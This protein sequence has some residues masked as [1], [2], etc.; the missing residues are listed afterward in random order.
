[1]KSTSHGTSIARKA[2]IPLEYK[3]PNARGTLAFARSTELNSA[4]SEWFF[5]VDDNTSVLDSSHAGG[6]AVFA[7]VLGSGMSVID[8]IAAVP[9]FNAGT[10]TAF[11]TLPLRNVTSNQAT[12]E[13]ANFI[14][15]N[16]VTVVPVYPTDNVSTAV[17]GFAVANNN[18]A[19]ASATL[20]GSTLTITP[21][22]AGTAT[23]SLRA[24]DVNGNFASSTIT[25]T[26]AATSSSPVITVPPVAQDIAAGS[27]AAFNVTAT[28]VPTPNYQ[29]KFN[30]ADISGA[31]SSRLVLSRGS[32]Q[33]GNYSVVVSNSIGS[34]T[35]RSVALTL[36]NTADVGRLANLSVLA[37]LSAAVPEFT[38][39]T[40]IGG[41]SS[42][43]KPMLVRAGGPTLG[44]APFSIPGVVSDT[45]L[46]LYAGST[47]TNFNDNW[48]VNGSASLAAVFASVGAYA[49][50]APDS[51]DSALYIPAAAPGSYSVKVAGVNGAMGLILAEIYDATPAGSFSAAAHRFQNVSVLKQIDATEFLTVGFNIGGSTARTV[52]VRAAGPA[53]GDLGVGGTMADPQ[54]ELYS[55]QTVLVANDNWGG[56]AAVSAV[57]TSVGAFAFQ[58]P[59][60]KDAV[61]VATLAPGSYT[62]VVKGVNGSS[63]LAIV[64]VYE[65]P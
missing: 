36:N 52:L 27:T 43:T 41:G 1:M 56:D 64:E 45:K 6:Y 30:G 26:V 31:T 20:T 15:I 42:G 54:L 17:L 37:G 29:W 2:P 25:V 63:G 53:L 18:S 5:N 39:A 33:A 38:V 40:V 19:V 55:G 48:G 7:R 62:A 61:I 3:L 10:G 32:A 24:G 49:Y 65:V 50:A 21:L 35:S 60:S 58:R 8:A 47:L 11:E 59:A 57:A 23:L 46:E 16:S 51:K 34:V 28:G 13:L 9:T 4:T 12:I 22:S 44:L 14:L